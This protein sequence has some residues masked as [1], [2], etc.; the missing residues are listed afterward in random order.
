M[1]FRLSAAEQALRARA[2][3]LADGVFRG[4]AARWDAAEEYPWDNV[5]DL[6]N[7]GFMGLAIPA[8]Y[9]GR[10]GSRRPPGGSS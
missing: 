7:A 8:A 6:V 9:G 2:R 4:R 5:K 3:E 10:G 1:D